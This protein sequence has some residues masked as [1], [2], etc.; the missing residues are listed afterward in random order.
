MQNIG[1]AVDTERVC[2]DQLLDLLLEVGQQEGEQVE[3]REAQVEVTHVE[4]VEEARD[5]RRLLEQQGTQTRASVLYVV[6]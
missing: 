2:D 4:D 6:R 3:Y 5:G 1:D